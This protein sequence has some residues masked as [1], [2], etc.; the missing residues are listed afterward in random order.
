MPSPPAASNPGISPAP[1]VKIAYGIV[2]VEDTE[3]TQSLL[4]S[5]RQ[6]LG[7]IDV[8]NARY[9]GL[10]A[11]SAASNPGSAAEAM[12]FDSYNP[13]AALVQLNS[14]HPLTGRRV[15]HLGEIAKEKRQAFA[16][17]DVEA[18]AARVHLDRGKLWGQFLG[19]LLLL[20][21]PLLFGLAATLLGAWQ[22]APAAI[23]LGVLA[24]LPLRYPFGTPPLSWG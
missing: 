20:I 16:D 13:W 1:W 3:A 2:A 12:L 5:A 8:K 18:A 11:E 14:T 24:T 6:H 7:V 15:A 10:L 9:T 19:E 21:A 22:L 4:R 23:A 17:Y